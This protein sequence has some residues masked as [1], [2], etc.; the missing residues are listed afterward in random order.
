MSR[1][2]SNQT[3]QINGT[4]FFQDNQWAAEAIQRSKRKIKN[5]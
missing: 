5:C 1:K 4:A 3:T 2:L